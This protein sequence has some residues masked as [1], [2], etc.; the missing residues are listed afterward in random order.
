MQR[1]NKNAEF[2]PQPLDPKS[3]ELAAAVLNDRARAAALLRQMT[4]TLTEQSPWEQRL[5]YQLCAAFWENQH[6]HFDAALEHLRLAQAL[7]E[8]RNDALLLAEIWLDRSA[9]LLNLTR[10]SDS[11]NALERTRKLLKNASNQRILA[12]LAA[13][14]G[15]LHL[16]LDNQGQALEYLLEAEKNLLALGQSATLKDQYELTLVIGGLGTL[17]E[18]RNE[19]DKSLDAYRRILP[20]V[21]AHR[22]WPRLAWH[23]LNT[24]RMLLAQDNPAEARDFFEKTLLAAGIGDEEAKAGALTNL[25]II[26]LLDDD[27]E[28]AAHRFDEGAALFH[29]PTKPSDYDNLAKAYWWRAEL[30]KQTG[31]EDRAEEN[32]LRGFEAG[33]AGGQDLYHQRRICLTLSELYERNDL[34]PQALEWQRRATQFTEDHYLRLRE[35]ERAELDARYELERSRQEAQMARLRVAGLQSRALRAQMNPHFLFNALNAIQ[36][37]ITSGRDTDA[38][39]YLARFAKFMRQTLEYAD[40]EEVRLDEEIQFIDKYLEINRKLRFR[41]Q[42]SYHIVP[43]RGADSS[44][45]MIPAMIVQPFVENAI[46]H[47]L[48]PKQSGTLT[49]RFEFSEDEKSLLCIVEDDGVGINQGREKQAKHSQ[50]HQTHRSRGMD[51]TRERLGLLHGNAGGSFVKINDLADLT[52]GE[53]NGT[54]VEVLLPLLD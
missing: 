32:L 38:A 28:Q 54:R 41:D 27:V 14:E 9:I 24:G 45:L 11:Q 3:A 34:T 10:W 31:E 51:I 5:N 4:S 37:F 48:R 22:L 33:Q 53:R 30:R 35:N 52:H 8:R 19:R 42:L 12:H 47:G 2:D 46:E 25:G 44:D 7:A 40:L 15:Q 36:G 1:S 23:Y 17:Y 29:T 18:R 20:I 13:R 16:R 21:E 49:V 6:Y 43:P 39:T 26:A 50:E